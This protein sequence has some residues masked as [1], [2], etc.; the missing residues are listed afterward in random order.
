[1]AVKS[2]E[3]KSSNKHQQKK[4]AA[5]CQ[6]WEQDSIFLH[7]LWVTRSLKKTS[8]AQH[9]QNRQ[10]PLLLFSRKRSGYFCWN[11]MERRPQLTVIKPMSARGSNSKPVAAVKPAKEESVKPRTR[12]VKSAKEGASCSNFRSCR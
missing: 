2:L 10:Q 4:L 5:D 8:P 12:Y 1:L 9:Q 7:C 11:L 6:N 3:N